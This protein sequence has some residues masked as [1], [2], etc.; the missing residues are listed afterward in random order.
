MPKFKVERMYKDGRVEKCTLVAESA[1][2]VNSLARVE[3][4][5]VLN[6]TQDAQS[7]GFSFQPKRP[8]LNLL[9]Q[10]LQ[11]LL[12]AGLS[13]PEVLAALAER[14]SHA[15]QRI[16]LQDIQHAVNQGQSLS[17]AMQLHPDYFAPLYIATIRSGEHTGDLPMV[18]GRY[19]RYS[20]QMDELKRKL[21]SAITYPTL[22]LAVGIAVVLF[23]LIYLVPRFSVIYEQTGSNLSLPA[24]LLLQWGVWS[25]EH[26]ALLLTGML[27]IP[28]LVTVAWRNTNFRHTLATKLFES[29]LLGRHWRSFNTSRYCRSLALLVG[30]GIPL[31]QA[32]HLA[33]GL[34][35]TLLA[36]SVNQA[37]E[38]IKRGRKLSDAL[39]QADLMT[40]LALRLIRAG[41]RSGDVSRMLERAADFHDRELAHLLERAGK[42]IEPLLMLFI[43]LM[44][45]TIV[46][47]M[48]L[49]I[50][51]L[52]GSLRP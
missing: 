21:L 15:L 51:E 8:S 40:P 52:A 50:F 5:T 32:M 45:G 2:A 37:I 17:A 33:S 39:A 14:E 4:W 10:E 36:E 47:L 25:K 20:E 18:I 38:D 28:A 13:L 34:L 12:E 1:A 22:L 9:S 30:G 11:T 16:M 35:P 44:I 23:L 42:L 24:T 31:T 3:S 26:P 43:G 41:E 46:V 48:Y 49:P 19:L 29:R 6:V 7:V 27:S